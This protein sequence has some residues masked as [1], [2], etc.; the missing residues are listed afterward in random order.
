MQPATSTKQL[1]SGG[2]GGNQELA[3]RV[4]GVRTAHRYLVIDLHRSAVLADPS[5]G[6]QQQQQQQ[7]AQGLEDVVGRFHAK[8]AAGELQPLSSLPLVAPSGTGPAAAEALRAARQQELGLGS[9]WLAS[10]VGGEGATVWPLFGADFRGTG[11][12]WAAAGLGSAQVVV[13]AFVLPWCVST[14]PPPPPPAFPSTHAHRRHTGRRPVTSQHAVAIAL[15]GRRRR[16]RRARRCAFSMQLEPLLAE[17][18]QVVSAAPAQRLF[19]MVRPAPPAPASPAPACKPHRFSAARRR[20]G[21]AASFATSDIICVRAGGC[22]AD[23]TGVAGGRACRCA[24]LP[25]HGYEPHTCR[26]I[27]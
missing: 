10:P 25:P 2:R 23:A 11:V 22:A 3:A 9:A 19:S 6:Q 27:W 5:V 7:P 15:N 12:D 1:R 14:L 17:L 13:V 26:A 21:H 4:R 8:F 18:E 20:L 24:R 16:R